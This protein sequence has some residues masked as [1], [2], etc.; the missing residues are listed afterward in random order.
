MK[1]VG[2]WT[3][4]DVSTAASSSTEVDEF[5]ALSRQ[6]AIAEFVM[7]FHRSLF[8]VSFEAPYQL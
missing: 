1:Q 6:M 4:I 8:A 2:D 5:F 3:T 7:A